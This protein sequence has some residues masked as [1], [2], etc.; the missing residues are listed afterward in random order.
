VV[1]AGLGDRA[2]FAF[3]TGG[4]LGRHQAGEASRR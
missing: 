2:L 3:R 4:V 1:V